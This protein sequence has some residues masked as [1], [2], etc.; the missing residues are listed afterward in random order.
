MK[1]VNKLRELYN[2]STPIDTIQCD[3]VDYKIFKDYPLTRFCNSK[4]LLSH[5]PVGDDSRIDA[6]CGFVNENPYF[7]M[8]PLTTTNSD[9]FYGFV[10][11]SYHQKQYRNVFCENNICSFIGF[12]NFSDYNGQPIVLCEGSKD[13]ITINKFY[14]YTLGCLTC[15]LG[16]DDIKAVTKLTKT[17]L[18]CYDNDKPGLKAKERDRERLIK[19]G[20]RVIVP[21]YVGKDPGDCYFNP[22]SFQ[23]LQNSVLNTLN[24]LV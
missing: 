4:E 13:F 9:E 24:S 10:I 23:I 12:N 1:V 17:I 2:Y 14:K 20:C 7:W 15:G 6:F 11:K 8:I 22:T 16:L 19:E 3:T 5:I 18:L 21:Y